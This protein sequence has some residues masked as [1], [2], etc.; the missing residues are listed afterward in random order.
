MQECQAPAPSLTWVTG[1][2]RWMDLV[3]RVLEYRITPN[4]VDPLQYTL[5][6]TLDCPPQE[7]GLLR[8]IIQEWLVAN[9]A[10]G[11][12]RASKRSCTVTVD[13]YVRQLKKTLNFHPLDVDRYWKYDRHRQ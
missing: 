7:P 11:K 2:V 1:L 9:H 4:E 5:T 8:D 12:I 3:M 10:G 6:V 13:I